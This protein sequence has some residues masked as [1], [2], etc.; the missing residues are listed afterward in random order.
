MDKLPVRL[1]KDPII[2]S[3]VEIRFARHPAVQ[4]SDLL[5]GMLFTNL[6]KSYP[7]LE[8]LPVSQIPAEIRKADLNLLFKPTRQ[9]SGNRFSISIG[10]NV[11]SVSCTRPYVGWS[12]FQPKI[13][14]VLELVKETGL[15]QRVGRVSVKYINIIPA[16]IG[17]KN[18]ASLKASVQ[19]G[20]YNLVDHGCTIRTDILENGINSIVQIISD[21]TA[22][23]VT[24]KEKISGLL[25]DIDS[26]YDCKNIN[27]WD[28]YKSII[29]DVR[30]QEK[31]IFFGLLTAETLNTLEPIWQE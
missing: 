11:L 2:E 17:G 16:Q 31:K 14:E 19:M 3:I 22:E 21:A 6:R 15:V 27:F 26:I 30:K 10:D 28:T 20:D 13:F 4:V 23:L 12:K 5:P 1:N 8:N 25:L 29:E 9:L 18:L 7:R 24:A